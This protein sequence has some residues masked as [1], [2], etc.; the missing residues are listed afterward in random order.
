V[1]SGRGATRTER[2]VD[3]VILGDLLS[4]AVA[5]QRGADAH[6]IPAIER[7][8]AELADAHPSAG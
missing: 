5:E 7:L 4:L 3:L 6:A 2:L 1:V 8:K